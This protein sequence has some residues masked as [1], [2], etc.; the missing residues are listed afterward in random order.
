M[1]VII[2]KERSHEFE[3]QQ[4]GV[5]EKICR[6]GKERRKWW[7]YNLKN[8]KGVERERVSEGKREGRGRRKTFRKLLSLGG[9][10]FKNGSCETLFY[11]VRYNI[12]VI[13]FSAM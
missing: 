4:G 6:E 7:S 3:E 12:S 1:H 13:G 10:A 11:H 9:F 2:I 5:Y 8:R